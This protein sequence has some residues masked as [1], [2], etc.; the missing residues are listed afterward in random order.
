MRD[1]LHNERILYAV[2]DWGLGH[3]VRSAKLIKAL[4]RHNSLTLLSSGIAYNWLKNELPKFDIL[5][6][7]A[8]D[9]NYRSPARWADMIGQ[10]P[11]LIK[12]I[13]AE[14]VLTQSLVHKLSPTL[15]ISDHRWGV[16]DKAVRSILLAHQLKIPL[17]NPFSSGLI[18]KLHAWMLR[19]F[20]ECWI[21]DDS[22]N[23]LSGEL[24][25]NPY[26]KMPRSYI[27]SLG[28]DVTWEVQA[29]H[30]SVAVILSGPEPMRTK[31]EAQIVEELR[32]ADVQLTIVRGMTQP[33]KL[34]YESHWQVIDLA[35]ES[36]IRDILASAET[37]ISRSG[38]TTIMDIA[39]S[40]RRH[41][42]IPTPGHPEQEY[43]GKYHAQNRDKWRVISQNE[44][45]TKLN[46]LLIE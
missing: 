22:S 10:A 3:A 17:G 23:S 12:T 35:T 41:I 36:E 16:Y 33:S 39:D 8:Y 6:L 30:G 1:L 9:I 25:N 14:N 34:I 28:L 13:R 4:S 31:L 40:P 18:N 38:Y 44:L 11:K 20:D 7:P 2:S 29:I 45:S 5:E 43:L 24:S 42:L 19:G 26:L 27:G 32:N 15:I 21:P 46:R 37:I